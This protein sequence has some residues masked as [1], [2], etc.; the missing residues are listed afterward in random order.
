MVKP[1]GPK[2][3]CSGITQENS[4]NSSGLSI[5]K[6]SC[7]GDPGDE[8][9]RNFRYQHAYGVILLTGAI[10]GQLPYSAL[11][12][13][14]HE[15]FLAEINDGQF[16]AYQIKTRKPEFGEWTL[17]HDPLRDSIRRFVY[18]DEK[19]PQQIRNF[20]F[21]SNAEFSNST[22]V[23]KLTKSPLQLIEAV[24]RSEG[25]KFLD[26][27]FNSSFEG[28]RSFCACS[29]DSL[30]KVLR[31][32][33]LYKGPSRDGFDAELSH[34][35]LPYVPGCE[36]FSAVKL[37]SLRDEL[38][39][40]VY[41]ASSLQV[42]GPSYQLICASG[43]T[44]IDPVLQAKRIDIQAV[45]ILIRE[46]RPVPFRYMPIVDRINLGTVNKSLAIMEKKMARGGILDQFEIMQRR[47]ISAENYLLEFASARPEKFEPMINQIVN[48]V[49]AECDEARLSAKLNPEP[50][51]P[52]MLNDVYA[53]LK[54][55]A[56][57]MPEIV[58]HQPY[59]CLIGIA[60]IMTGECK[61]W[62]SD[63]FD[64]GTI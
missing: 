34:N 16:D 50:I 3:H 40:V 56:T 60:G 9:Q 22:A 32:L 20:F 55:V 49:Q 64:L 21:I 57:N 1:K 62:W 13:E 4:P 5:A 44:M 36:S 31:R 25:I 10:I 24:K 58:E 51:G 11:W 7:K 41:K 59:E 19:F 37:N 2:R 35:Y 38:I 45:G 30:W 53:R 43:D 28:L 26:K 12:C 48:I 39:Q 15:D 23:T 42:S 33:K 54:V 46:T 8:T 61:I 6:V 17:T 52:R 63:E 18:L 27:Q 29:A 14:H 47:A